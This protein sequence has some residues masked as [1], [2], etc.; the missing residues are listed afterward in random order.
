MGMLLLRLEVDA[1]EGRYRAEFGTGDAGRTVI[2]LIP[3]DEAADIREASIEILTTEDSAGSSATHRLLA[4]TYVDGSG[5]RTRFEIASGKPA[6]DAD[7][8]TPPIE[9]L[10]D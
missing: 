8:E 7:F 4:L 6:T 9:W 3:T 1:L 2:R 5:N 10:E